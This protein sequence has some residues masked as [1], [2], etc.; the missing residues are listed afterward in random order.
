MGSRG[1]YGIWLR[2]Q[3]GR[4]GIHGHLATIWRDTDPDTRPKVSGIQSVNSWVAGAFSEAG[5]DHDAAVAALVE[6]ANEWRGEEQAARLGQAMPPSESLAVASLPGVMAALGRIERVLGE[7]VTEVR[8]GLQPQMAGMLAWADAQDQRL[9]PLMGLIAELQAGDEA[10]V[11]GDPAIDGSQEPPGTFPEVG[12]GGV[13]AFYGQPVTVAAAAE[14]PGPELWA[15]VE[16][17]AEQ[18]S[19]EHGSAGQ[20]E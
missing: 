10:G 18:G 12:G 14:R 9:G 13:P 1:T 15:A 8:T 17:A 4:P 3:H 7:L 11:L 6:L 16:A 5:G 19:P 20:A 2:E